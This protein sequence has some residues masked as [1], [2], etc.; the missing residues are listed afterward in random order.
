MQELEIE[1]FKCYHYITLCY[2]A[3]LTPCYTESCILLQWFTITC[4]RYLRCFYWGLQTVSTTHDREQTDPT[5]NIEFV[6]ETL[7]YLIG[8][9]A[10]A[11]IIGEVGCE[12]LVPQG[13][14]LWFPGIQIKTYCIP[15][16]FLTVTS[17]SYHISH[18]LHRL[19][20]S[21]FWEL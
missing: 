7:G 2:K 12:I 10:L 14:G 16:C 11:V 19:S 1:R 13:K 9:F 3:M 15:I 6:A 20:Q 4:H 18:T 5:N 8:V 21:F 17:Q